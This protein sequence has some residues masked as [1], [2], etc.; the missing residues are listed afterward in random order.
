MNKT[1]TL[2]ELIATATSISMVGRDAINQ[3]DRTN[4]EL[5]NETLDA[6]HEQLAIAGGSLLVLAEHLGCT[7]QVN[8]LL[9]EARARLLAY[10]ASSGLE[11]RA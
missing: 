6:L 1:P 2:A 8:Q 10:K 4:L 5:T 7:A 9:S 3:T 11:G